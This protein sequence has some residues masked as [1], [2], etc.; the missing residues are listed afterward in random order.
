MST[1]WMVRASVSDFALSVMDGHGRLVAGVP[2]AEGVPPLASW[3]LPVGGRAELR[4]PGGGEAA[5]IRALLE[6]TS[7]WVW[8]VDAEARYTYVSPVVTEILGYTPAELIGKTPFDCMAPAEAARVASVFGPIAAAREPLKALENINLH[9]DGRE[10]LLETSG[11]PIFDEAGAFVGYRGIDR[12]ITD[13]RRALIRLRAN[14]VAFDNLAEGLVIADTERRIV[15]LNAAFEALTGH[16]GDAVLGQ[17]LT[18]LD[19]DPEAESGLNEILAAAEQ[20][21]TWRGEFTARRKDGRAVPLWA[22]VS[23]VRAADGRLHNY[24]AVLTDITARKRA[25]EAVWRQANFDLLTGL[26]NRRLFYDRLAKALA[27]AERGGHGLSLL[28]VD[29]DGFKAVNDALGHAVGDRVLETTAERL[30]GVVRQSDTVA[31][32]SGD[33]FVI[34]LERTTDAA[35]PGRVA[36]AVCAVLRRPFEVDGHTLRLSA[37]VGVAVS[38]VDGT[39]A[40]GLLQ[41][42]DAAL[43]RVKRGGKDGVAFSAVEFAQNAQAQQALEQ[44]LAEALSAGT[45]RMMQGVHAVVGGAVTEVGATLRWT[46]PTRGPV[47]PMGV[48]QLAESVRLGT[49]LGIFTVRRA[50]RDLRVLRELGVERVS[51]NISAAIAQRLM[52]E[53]TLRAVLAQGGQPSSALT[54]ELSC[55]NGAAELARLLPQ[56]ESLRAEGLRVALDNFGGDHADLRQAQQLPVDAIKLDRRLVVGAVA[57][58]T[59]LLM[60]RAVVAIAADR[61]VQ[62]IGEGVETPEQLAML[63]E[64]G[65]RFAQGYYFERPTAAAALAEAL[66]SR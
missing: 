63:C 3:S 10:V 28:Y 51:V 7:D 66:R 61:G 13:S 19:D 5:H 16:T 25:E 50:L 64:E 47:E 38:P 42:A 17:S 9:R 40:E 44:G 36:R 46:H 2:P 52:R 1:G 49:E 39:G 37:S 22:S 18:V 60:L 59:D 54:L 20:R 35:Q 57:G 14:K 53:G 27:R 34:M 6:S 31:R 45:L 58:G 43:Y 12:D 48:V 4:R 32:M 33:E 15:D 26:P 62:I 56:L 29:L 8:E 11:V 23:A 55:R 24:V 21:G 65:V 30:L 41:A